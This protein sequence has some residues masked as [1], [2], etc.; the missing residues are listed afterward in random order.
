MT[1]K[2]DAARRRA[3]SLASPVPKTYVV[4]E[5]METSRRIVRGRPYRWLNHGAVAG[6]KVR[7]GFF[8]FTNDTELKHFASFPPRVDS[9]GS[10]ERAGSLDATASFL[11]GIIH[12]SSRRR[13]NYLDGLVETAA[14]TGRARRQATCWSSVGFMQCGKRPAGLGRGAN[15]SAVGGLGRVG[16]S[17]DVTSG[18]TDR[19]RERWGRAFLRPFILSSGDG[20]TTQGS[21]LATLDEELIYKSRLPP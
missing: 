2:Y 14:P 11:A 21:Y 3:V 13:S 18:L 6:G 1:D 4:R 16:T 7:V 8:F 12:A 15:V 19:R 17:S 20:E 9:S 5:D 10:R